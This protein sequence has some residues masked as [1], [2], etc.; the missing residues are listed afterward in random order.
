MKKVVLGI[1]IIVLI[2]GAYGIYLFNKKP[3]D[4]REKKSDFTLT[5]TE[6]TTE[7]SAD[8]AVASKKYADKVITLVG[9]VT[10]VSV[11][12]HT[13]FLEGADPLSG[14][15]C[16]FY[17]DEA[18]QFNSYPVGASARIKGKCTGKLTDVVLNNC[19]FLKP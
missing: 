14:V 16:T 12:T 19:S 9:K 6:L 13:I 15:T 18:S 7:F 17:E 11:S 1:P 4:I 3:A 5:A 10:D 8:E 2:A